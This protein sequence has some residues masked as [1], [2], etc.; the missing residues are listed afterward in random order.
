MDWSPVEKAAKDDAGNY[1][2]LVG[3]S[4]RPASKVAKNDAGAYVAMFDGAAPE[5]AA[6]AT[7]P[8]VIPGTIP[9]EKLQQES[10]A[11][12]AAYRAEH[13]ALGLY[14]K[15]FEKLIDFTKTPLGDNIL[16]TLEGLMP[17]M[18]GSLQQIAKPAAAALEKGAAGAAAKVAALPDFK[19]PGSGVV[20][21][22]TGSTAKGAAEALKQQATDLTA[23]K[24]D[25]SKAAAA[26]LERQLSAVEAAQGQ[27]AQ[28][29]KVAAARAAAQA[30]DPARAAAEK[31]AVREKAAARARAAEEEHRK[32]GATVEQAKAA[33]Q[34]AESRHTDAQAAVDAMEQE[35][36][37]K[38]GTSKE[39]FG[40]MVRSAVERLRDKY[41]GIR[42]QAAKFG[43]VIEDAGDEA[44]VATKGVDAVI[45]SNLKG[46]KNPNLQSVLE[47]IQSLIGGGT[48]G[49]PKGM[50]AEMNALTAPAGPASTET[51]SLRQADSLKKYLDSIIQTRQMKDM[52]G[53]AMAVDKETM[54]VV[55]DVK[56]ALM[57]SMTSEAHPK[58]AAYRNALEQF[59]ENSRP[60][61]IVERKGALRPVL[62]MD[63]VSSEYALTEAQV[64][65]K[66][67]EKARAGNPTMTRLLAES[68]ELK[69][70]AR[71]YFTQDLFG[72]GAVPTEAGLKTWLK[73]NA[74]PL[75][76]LGLLDEFKDMKA[77]RAAAQQAVQEANGG[78]AQA[79]AGV[80]AA[81]AAEAAAGKQAGSA[82][83][84]S[85]MSE[86][87]LQKAL[88]ATA[89]PQDIA[90]QS[91]KRAESAGR[92]LEAKGK[93]LT[94]SL[95]SQ[96]S[97]TKAFDSFQTELRNTSPKEVPAKV[98]ALGK[99]LVDDGHITQDEYGK[100]LE[101]A[102][103]VEKHFSDSAKTQR[104]M[105]RIAG[106]LGIGAAGKYGVKAL[107]D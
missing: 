24:L 13:P 38:P 74:E 59:R 2:G 94:R 105:L 10:K 65:G 96:K 32:A 6:P 52:A 92:T 72:A 85:K 79:E 91:G 53:N 22:A 49:A 26:P 103:D 57:D 93:Q 90:A 88:G 35:L 20:G 5:P 12:D 30:P 62:D 81:K 68:P 78:V 99:K 61:D 19:L 47:R 87:R 1:Q 54:V 3:G 106:I 4:W 16:K 101:Q 28:Q 73:T 63:P 45:E 18:T 98:R 46:I 9:A 76:Q 23:G 34:Q 21:R 33:A 71:L 55:R 102:A 82:V 51:L 15:Q 25:A 11:Q 17:G 44:V 70:S 27:M 14:K 41:E 80:S 39:S 40:G 29:P 64:V 84:V 36:L 75:R 58:T 95:E 77:A 50:Q 66:V 97:V 83:K 31:I 107:V 8:G 104:N 48:P 56:K 60:L 7:P 86:E 67:I 43:K 42:G 89:K 69:D 37:S 100:M